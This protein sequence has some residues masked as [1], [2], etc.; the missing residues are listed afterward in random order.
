[1]CSAS[2]QGD[3]CPINNDPHVN[4]SK[5]DVFILTCMFVVL[6]DCEHTKLR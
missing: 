1:M 6:R 4:R 2:D 3:S 5:L